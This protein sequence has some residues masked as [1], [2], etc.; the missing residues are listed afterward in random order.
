MHAFLPLLIFIVRL[1]FCFI[2]FSVCLLSICSFLF[3]LCNSLYRSHHPQ[4]FLFFFL[5]FIVFFFFFFFPDLLVSETKLVEA[6][7]AGA[8]WK[9]HITC[10]PISRVHINFYKAFRPSSA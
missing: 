8:F 10:M 4:S 9:H 1:V 6:S 2:F 5:F 3:S 7:A